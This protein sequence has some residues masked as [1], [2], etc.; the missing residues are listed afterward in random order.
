MAPTWPAALIAAGSLLAVI[1]GGQV[2]VDQGAVSGD[3][4]AVL[5]AILS[6]SDVPIYQHALIAACFA[7]AWIATALSRRVLQIPPVRLG[8]PVLAFF[9]LVGLS[10]GVAVCKSVAIES[11][12]E[13]FAYAI[14]FFSVVAA[15]GRKR[16]PAA[17]MLGIFVGC[18]VLALMGIREYESVKAS[19]PTHR[20]FASWN[21]P[22]AL[23]SILT[24]GL[25]LGLGLTLTRPRAQSLASAA[26]S[27]LIGFAILLT[28]SKGSLL[29]S[30]V[31][32]LAL[33]AFAIAAVR[34]FTDGLRKVGRVV[35][36]VAA[37]GVLGFALQSS[38]KRGA[39]GAASPFTR[40]GNSA[41]SAEQ[42]VGF[43]KNLQN[44]AISLIKSNP[45]GDGIGC[46]RFDSTR[47]GLVMH[48]VMAHN[49]LLQLG[50]EATPLAPVALLFALAWWIYYCVRG[51]RAVPTER[52]LVLASI[53]VAVSGLFL[54]GMFES[55][56]YYFG[57]GIVFFGL[58]GVGLLLAAD[59]PAPEFA[60]KPARIVAAILA[61]V[62]VVEL[63]LA[64]MVEAG[65][66]TV[67]FERAIG[68]ADS[69]SSARTRIDSLKSLGAGD[70]EV[71]YLSGTLRS[72]PRAR[73]D[74]FATAVGLCPL[75]K[76]SRALARSL[77]EAREVD[78]AIVVL[79]DCLRIDPNNLTALVQLL[80][81]QRSSG[82]LAGAAE[83]AR[84][85][86]AVES[87][88]YFKTRAIPEQVPTETAQARI[89][90][91]EKS[92]KV[93]EKIAL[94]EPAVAQLAQHRAVT[95]PIVR[96]FA[97]SG[98]DYAGED[99]ARG[100]QTMRLGQKAAQDLGQAYRAAGDLPAA[101]KAD[102]EAALFG[103]EIGL[104]GHK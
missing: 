99:L 18:F 39:A 59:A 17:L 104:G 102:A 76:Y 38:A 46:F 6:G 93:A 45:S 2:A 53:I 32:A 79:K 14:A 25:F 20:I 96:R 65:K 9:G 3:V 27:V 61:G 75:A 29:V 15:V 90:L 31:G 37:I 68:G 40:L 97:E 7:I 41:Q 30:A 1:L 19:E 95:M 85:L 67:R 98:L 77:V 60:P 103:G 87:T 57:I 92:A 64:G 84:K 36:C 5:G 43:R 48:T 56:L 100:L 4:G 80:E 72:E 28:Q 52:K 44:T 34:P 47:P 81:T 82:D 86:V 10:V 24:V 12:A 51:M 22:N 23:G 35:A 66:A 94:L 63:I 26:G 83:T 11:A 13:W 62:V 69:I 71:W 73:A 21:N 101:A 58:L 74:E 8:L 91:A 70:G 78:R 89:F 33:C 50:V 54:D 88:P 16:G 55:N 42:S 49:N